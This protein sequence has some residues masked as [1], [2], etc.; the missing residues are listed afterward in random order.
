M[1]LKE[2]KNINQIHNVIG[3][4]IY[5]HKPY[6]LMNSADNGIVLSSGTELHIMELK[7][8]GEYYN[9]CKVEVRKHDL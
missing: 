7:N 2:I 5:K 6:M 9:N 1:K 4:P 8:Y 3:K